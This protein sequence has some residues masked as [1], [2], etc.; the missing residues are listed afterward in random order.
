MTVKALSLAA[1]HL[2]YA[3]PTLGL[4]R[5][6]AWALGFF[7]SR[8]GGC[9]GH[10]VARG[11]ADPLSFFPSTSTEAYYHGYWSSLGQ[12]ISSSRTDIA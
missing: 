3:N 8:W 6:A 4:T 11:N 10:L 9:L 7:A 1:Y 12:Q 5:K 2:Y